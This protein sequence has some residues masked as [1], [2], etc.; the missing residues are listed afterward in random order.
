MN[1]GVCENDEFS[2]DGGEG[3]FFLFAGCDESVIEDFEG[4]IVIAGGD[5]GHVEGAADM[6]ASAFDGSALDGRR[7]AGGRQGLQAPQGP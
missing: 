2:H 4:R 7:H 5:G 1:E 3:D 6:G